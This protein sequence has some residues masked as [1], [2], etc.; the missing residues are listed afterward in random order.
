MNNQNT[1][2]NQNEHEHPEHLIGRLCTKLTGR[3]SGRTAII[4][5]VLEGN[6]VII[7]GHVKRRRCNLAHLELSPQQLNLPTAASSEEI[8]KLLEKQ[9]ISITQ[10]NKKFQP[11]QKSSSQKPT[12]KRSHPPQ[13]PQPASEQQK[14]QPLHSESPRKSSSTKSEKKNPKKA[15]T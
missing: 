1:Q 15:S 4:V 14:T 12:K 2:S 7:D 9:G 3:E 5:E 8:S 11:K 10:P 6:F 13:Q